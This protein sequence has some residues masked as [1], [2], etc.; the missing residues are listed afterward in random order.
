VAARPIC[1]YAP[2]QA[3]PFL[4]CISRSECSR[5]SSCSNIPVADS[6]VRISPEVVRSIGVFGSDRVS[7][8]SGWI[9]PCLPGNVQI[10][11]SRSSPSDG[12]SEILTTYVLQA[13][14]RTQTRMRV[15]AAAHPGQLCRFPL[16]NWLS[17][18]ADSKAKVKVMFL[19]LAGGT[20][21]VRGKVRKPIVAPMRTCSA[22]EQFAP[23]GARKNFAH[24]RREAP[25]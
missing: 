11:H 25:C 3:C 16:P 22:L 4:L 8:Y 23:G 21:L 19:H 1:F 5:A 12:N 9:V 15:F 14:P 20:W 18:C 10:G 7:S 24:I 2:L 13:R 17:V 6:P